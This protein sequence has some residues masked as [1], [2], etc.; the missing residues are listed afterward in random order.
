MKILMG[1]PLSYVHK[2]HVG[3]HNYSKLFVNDGHD[4][5]W[6]GGTLHLMNAVRAAL[7]N[8]NDRGLIAH[9]RNGSTRMNDHLRTYHPLTLLPYRNWRF[10]GS[11]WAMENT[12]PFTVPPVK[13]ILRKYGFDQPD[14]LWMGQSHFSLSLLNMVRPRKF[15]YRVLDSFT[16]F[17]GVPGSMHNIEAELIQ[18]ADTVFVT[19]RKLFEYAQRIGGEKVVLLPNGADAD[20]FSA[21]RPEPADLSQFRRPRVLYIGAIS[22]WFDFAMLAYAA[23]QRPDFDFILIGPGHADLSALKDLAN[24][25]ILGPR[26]YTDI[27]AYMQHSDI[28]IIP[29]VKDDLTHAI[30]PIKMFEYFAAGLPVVAT[31]LHEIEQLAPP[32]LLI[33]SR[34]D[35]VTALDEAHRAGR[36]RPEFLAYAQANSWQTRYELIKRYFP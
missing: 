13:R 35:F 19:A 6:L 18:R 20:H 5:F 28:G 32:A 4:V 11:R 27:P 30:S 33:D 36:S 31:R 23:Q 17:Q 1:E 14:V 34:E 16:D 25:H 8:P 3:S 21:A 29:F 2:V 10:L 24:V 15:I 26:P 9:W 12:L 22:Y 7:G